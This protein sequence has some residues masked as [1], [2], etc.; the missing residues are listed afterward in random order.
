MQRVERIQSTAAARTRERGLLSEV[1]RHW[2]EYLCISPFFLLFAIFFAYPIVWSLILSFQQWDGVTDATW[3]GLDNYRFVLRDPVTRQMFSN[4]VFYLL[5]L[6]PLGLILPLFFGVILNLPFL[7]L[8]GVFRTIIFIPTVTSVVVVGIVWR[9]VFGSANGWLNGLLANIG[10]GPYN[11]LKE[12]MLAQF[13]IVSLTVW[14][15]L[16]FATLIVLGGL[17]AIDQEIYDAARVDGASA[18]SIFWKITLPLMRPVMIFLLI[19]STIQ[20]MTLFSQPYVVTRGGPSNE[21]LTPLLHIYNIGVGSTGAARI[22]DS[23]ALSFLLSAAMLIIVAIQLRLTRRR[24][25]D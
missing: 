14:G 13:P 10:L 9:L 3:V 17:Q 6:V 15:G 5:V 2:R 7:R 19:T 25:E 12:P 24:G 18:W 16:G 21:T 22:G 11:W 1:T 20:V 8:R 23:T 4:T